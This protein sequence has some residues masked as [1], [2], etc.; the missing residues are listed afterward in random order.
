M[1]LGG[2]ASAALVESWTT[3]PTC[4]LA[5]FLGA[6]EGLALELGTEARATGPELPMALV[7]ALALALVLVLVLGLELGP[8]LMP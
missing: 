4:V 3:L 1:P 2:P 7:L 6:A 5:N 8:T